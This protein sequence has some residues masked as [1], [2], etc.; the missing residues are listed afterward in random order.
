MPWPMYT[1]GAIRALKSA[2]PLHC[3]KVCSM[4]TWLL[5]WRRAA[6]VLRPRPVCSFMLCSRSITSEAKRFSWAWLSLALSE[7][8][9]RKANSN[10]QF[11]SVSDLPFCGMELDGFCL[12]FFL[13]V[14]VTT[15][16][17]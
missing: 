11:S 3:L 8:S 2:M 15:S 1:M 10:L 16:S 14:V 5:Y 17:S 9:I 4:M 6:R 13:V 7:L 12:L